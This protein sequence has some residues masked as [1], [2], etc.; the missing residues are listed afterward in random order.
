MAK[1]GVAAV[2]FEHSWG[3]GVAVLRYFTEILKDSN[4][5]PFVDV[6]TKPINIK[7]N[8]LVKE[9]CKYDYFNFSLQILPFLIL[10]FCFSCSFSTR[11]QSKK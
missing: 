11:R 5:N 1:D 2:N 4:D 6:G 9:L 3:D 10:L 7:P 8:E